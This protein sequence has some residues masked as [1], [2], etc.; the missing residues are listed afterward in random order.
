MKYFEL[1]GHMTYE[2]QIVIMQIA[3]LLSKDLRVLVHLD[4]ELNRELLKEYP[5]HLMSIKGFDLC[6]ER[7]GFSE[8]PYEII[9]STEASTESKSDFLI[10]TQNYMDLNATQRRL[11]LKELSQTLPVVYLHWADSRIK[12]RY[13]QL[14]LEPCLKGEKMVDLCIHDFDERDFTAVNEY[15]YDVKGVF[16]GHTQAYKKVLIAILA[17]ILEGD[18]KSAKGL[19]HY[20]EQVK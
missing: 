13:A 18:V 2:K 5:Q 4:T 19:L 14:L 12:P 3:Q 11:T 7:G 1:I 20:G 6:T 10:L 8:E 15:F 16:K 17:H 9:F